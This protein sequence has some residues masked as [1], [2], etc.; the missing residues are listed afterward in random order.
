MA[1]VDLHHVGQRRA[2]PEA[3][4][5]VAGTAAAAFAAEAAVLVLLGL[6]FEVNL[7]RR[8][9]GAGRLQHAILAL[10]EHETE[11]AVALRAEV[12]D[13]RVVE[14]GLGRD[15][16]EERAGAGAAEA[17]VPARLDQLAVGALHAIG[18][19]AFEV[20]AAGGITDVEIHVLVGHVAE[21]GGELDALA[22]LDS[23]PIGDQ[24]YL[25]AVDNLAAD[26]VDR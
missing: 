14:G 2:G 18:R 10:A 12:G 24:P 23:L 20:V 5:L 11:L 1:C 16:N 8:G 9:P 17:D 22:R 13:H 15:G 19:A 3:G 25:Q 7:D 4:I 21:A 6:H 26:L